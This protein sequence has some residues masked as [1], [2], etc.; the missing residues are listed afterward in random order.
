MVEKNIEKKKLGKGNK[1]V[2]SSNS[3][4]K[5]YLEFYNSNL[6]RK[7]AICYIIL[8]IIFFILISLY[9]SNIN[10]QNFSDIANDS[11]NLADTNIFTKILKEKIPLVA[12]I[13]FAGI[14]PYVYIPVM[15]FIYSGSLADEIFSVFSKTNNNLNLILSSIGGIIQLFGI[16]LVIATGIYYC[17]MVTKRSKYNK[18]KQFGINDFKRR[19]FELTKNEKKIGEFNKKEEDEKQKREKFNVKIS[20]KNILIS[21]GIS[22]IIVIIGTLIGQV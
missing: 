4:I 13:A 21:T 6:K 11:Q 20:Y 1:K 22:M 19:F 10:T 16:G 8:M 2:N 5:E 15:G 3:K 14:T 18:V 12:I 17:S 7:H 9:I